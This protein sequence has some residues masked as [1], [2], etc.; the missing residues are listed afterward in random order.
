MPDYPVFFTVT[1]LY[2]A[3][4]DDMESLTATVIIT[5]KVKRGNLIVGFDDVGSAIGFIPAPVV[6]M[7]DTDGLVKLRSEPD[8]PVRI[9][10]TVEDLPDPGLT[11]RTYKVEDTGQ[12]YLW[13]AEE[14][15]YVETL[16][17][18]P[19]RLLADQHLTAVDDE[20][21]YDVQ[22]TK[23]KLN[24][25]SG[26]LSGFEFRALTYDTSVSLAEL[27]AAS[28]EGGDMRLWTR[29]ESGE[30][31]RRF[32]VKPGEHTD[33]TLGWSKRLV[34][35]D[36]ISAV[37]FDLVGESVGFELF[38]PTASGHNAQAWVRGTPAVGARQAAQCKVTTTKGRTLVQTFVLE[39]IYPAADSSPASTTHAYVAPSPDRY[40]VLP[41][42][43]SEENDE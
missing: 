25:L 8:L 33:Y 22:F 42:I 19:L 2:K 21:F 23:V 29:T 34:E 17:Y 32:L 3:F 39:A 11:T 41:V 20:L 14:S 35:D 16:G 24:G 12:H 43:P 28:Y 10:D 38:S 40:W 37:A 13:D 5:P 18:V 4:A 27:Q 1:G 31:V 7:I 6:A 36:S 9:V 26:R 30:L 15:E